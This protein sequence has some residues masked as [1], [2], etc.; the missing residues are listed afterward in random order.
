L[1]KKLKT[2]KLNCLLFLLF[3]FSCDFSPRLQ[4]NVLE[5][6]RYII[7][8][9]YKSAVEVYR[10]ILQE[11]PPL[12]IRIKIYYQTGELLC[13][14]LYKCQEATAF[15]QKI[16]DETREPAWQIKAQEK[17][18]EIYFYYLSDY[19]KAK[20]YYSA[21]VKV[22]PNLTK[23]N[24]YKWQWAMSLFNLLKVDTALSLL[25]EISLESK[26]E[27]KQEVL[28]YKGKIYFLQKKWEPAIK[29]WELYLKQEKIQNGVEAI[30]LMANSYET[31]EKL[32]EAYALYYSILTKYPDPKIIKDRLKSIYSRRVAQNR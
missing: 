27:Y 1:K 19:Q 14:H 3:L 8:Q 16:L 28:F 31:L 6:Q 20:D 12:S 2:K 7:D 29:S 17:L 13:F 10:S 32:K 22:R 25:D 4:K 24:F 23:R 30:F 26:N 9:D 21:L 15:Y 18:A 11:E 5:A